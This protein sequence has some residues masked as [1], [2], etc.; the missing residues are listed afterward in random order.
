[1]CANTNGGY[2]TGF[3][4]GSRLFGSCVHTHVATQAKGCSHQCNAGMDICY[5]GYYCNDNSS[6][7]LP[8]GN[9]T[10]AWIVGCSVAIGARVYVWFYARRVVWCVGSIAIIC[11]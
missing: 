3:D 7:A 4:D 1:M 2:R 5:N 9:R 6:Y 11:H 10:Y 8:V